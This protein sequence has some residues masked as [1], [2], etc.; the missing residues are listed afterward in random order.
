M[1]VRDKDGNVLFRKDGYDAYTATL[2]AYMNL[3]TSMRNSLGAL[4][5]I[6]MSA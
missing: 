3:G 4:V 1:P 2:Y 5:G 6:N